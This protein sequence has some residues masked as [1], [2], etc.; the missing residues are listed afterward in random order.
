MLCD[1]ELIKAVL[2]KDFNHFVDRNSFKSR[3]SYGKVYLFNS[4]IMTE[5]DQDWKL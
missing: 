1:P 4:L 5:I 3:Y 2:V